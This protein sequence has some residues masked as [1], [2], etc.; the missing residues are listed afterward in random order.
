MVLKDETKIR[1]G[2]GQPRK[3]DDLKRNKEKV[4][5]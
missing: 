3:M 1:D 4:K 5:I 2:I